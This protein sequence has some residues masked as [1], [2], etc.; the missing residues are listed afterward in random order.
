MIITVKKDAPR[1]EVEHLL[2]QIESKGLL[3]TM[4]GGINYVAY[5][6]V[7]DTTLLD[8]EKIAGL[9]FVENVQ[10]ITAPYRQ[11]SRAMHPQDTIVD[12]CGQKIGAGQKIAVMAGPCSVESQEHILTMAKIVKEAGAGFVRGGAYK[13]RSSPYSFQGLE[14]EGVRYLAQTKQVTGLPVVSEIMSADKLDEFVQ[15]VDIIQVGARN[16]QNFTLLKELGK[17]DKPV[18]LKRGLSAT[19]EEWLMSAEYICA[20]GNSNV[21]LCERGIRTFERYTRNTLDLS[22]IPVIKQKSHLPIVIDP[23]HATG[24]RKLVEPMA[25]AAIAAGA[26][27]LEIEVHNE[28]NSALSDGA[29]SLYP[30]QFVQLLEK[31]R[32]IAG[33]IGREL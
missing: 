32:A 27:G 12:I 1:G 22:V 10:R 30:D 13:P 5:G 18:L 23:S 25:L 17:I 28:P 26:D 14:T 21:I 15:Y 4:I 29:Q 6:V 3:A 24:N 9:S 2:D 19:I 20:G 31:G 7:G 33:V 16:M 8:V 11:V